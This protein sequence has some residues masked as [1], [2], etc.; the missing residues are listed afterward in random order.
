MTSGVMPACRLTV[1]V[2]GAPFGGVTMYGSFRSSVFTEASSPVT[3]ALTS[4]DVAAFAF[5]VERDRLA[6]DA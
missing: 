5:G 1:P 2:C 6:V 4:S 3:S